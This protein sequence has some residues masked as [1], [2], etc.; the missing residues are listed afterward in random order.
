MTSELLR[1][2]ADSFGVKTY[3]CLTG[4]KYIAEIV[5]RNEGKE[6]FVCG[7]EESYGFN[8]GEFVRD[9]DAPVACI[10]IAEC[11]A[12][13]AEK[14]LT[15]YQYLQKIYEEYGYYREGLVSLVRKGK[16]GVEEI[17]A[18]MADYRQNPPAALASSPV[19]KVS[20]PSSLH[21]IAVRRRRSLKQARQRLPLSGSFSSPVTWFSHAWWS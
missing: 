10:M 3:N 20:I 1:A 7:G 19:V 16:A 18:I 5:K 2:I 17:A 4:F 15:L 8:I 11:A 14:G 6:V 12:W 9:K 21:F 13:C